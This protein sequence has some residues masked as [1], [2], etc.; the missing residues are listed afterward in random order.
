[1]YFLRSGRKFTTDSGLLTKKKSFWF[2]FC[3]AYLR[4][5]QLLS[6]QHKIHNCNHQMNLERV[7]LLHIH[8]LPYTKEYPNYPQIEQTVTFKSLW[9]VFSRKEMNLSRCYMTH[10]KR[11]NKSPL[12]HVKSIPSFSRGGGGQGDHCQ[13]WKCF[14]LDAKYTNIAS[15]VVGGGESA[16]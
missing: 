16:N 8:P 13:Y 12:P 5:L 6:L 14:F 4:Y 15:T 9:L 7:I 10:P 1:M 2:I 11:D 3:F